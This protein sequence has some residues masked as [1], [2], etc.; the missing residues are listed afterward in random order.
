MSQ[1]TSPPNI[2]TAP[3]HQIGQADLDRAFVRSVAWN[4][5]ARW[6][7]QLLTWLSTIFVARMLMPSD[8]GLVGMATVFTGLVTLLSEVGLGTAVVA[9]RDLDRGRIAQ[10]NTLGVLL[11]TVACLLCVAVA[12]PLGSFFAPEV[13]AIVLVLSV[14]FVIG[15][16]RVVPHAL[17]KRRLQFK[18]LSLIE[19]SRALVMA[20]LTFM[21]AWFGFGY[22]ALVAALVGS[23]WFTTGE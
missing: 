17:L 11:G 5:V 2:T 3:S 22:W 12:R 9:L 20:V 21:L 14:T 7:S 15:G 8:Y 10:I 16:F 23:A 19:A 18:L 13:T 4:S 6:A 1:A